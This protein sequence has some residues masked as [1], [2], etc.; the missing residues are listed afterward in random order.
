MF[1]RFAQEGDEQ[2]DAAD[3]D[4]DEEEGNPFF[5]STFSKSV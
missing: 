1:C 4:F 3:G 2:L 5:Y